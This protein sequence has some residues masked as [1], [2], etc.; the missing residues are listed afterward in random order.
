MPPGYG[1]PA[2]PGPM[3]VPAPG[4]A[5]SL[6][7]PEDIEQGKTWALLGYL[8][9]PLWIIPLVQRDN[10][11]ALYHAK[12]SLALLIAIVIA[13][14]PIS[15]IGTITCGIGFILYL[16]LMYPWIMGVVYSAQGQYRPVPWF[17]FIADQYLQSIQ[18]DKRPGR[19]PR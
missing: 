7:P 10:A 17:G 14:I 3:A 8:I 6:Y 12:Q 15:I 4:P 9:S 2:L 18:A 16:P 5:P 13:T 1:A 19:P 11:F